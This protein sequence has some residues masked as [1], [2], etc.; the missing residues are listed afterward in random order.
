MKKSQSS[1]YFSRLEKFLGINEEGNITISPILIKNGSYQTYD[2]IFTY[3][4]LDFGEF[5]DTGYRIL[6][7]IDNDELILIGIGYYN[8]SGTTSDNFDIY[9]VSMVN[10][11]FEYIHLDNSEYGSEPIYQSVAFMEHTQSK[12]YTHRLTLTADKSYTLIYESTNNLNVSSI[13]DLRTITNV[14]A[15]S[16]N[17]ILPVCLTDLSGTAALQ[18]TTTLC[19]VGTA[20]VTAVSDKVTTL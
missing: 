14:K 15:T 16:D 19:K 1:E 5:K 17:V 18:I 8:I 13:A 11:D 20:N 3:S 7:L 12:L 2:G 9:G 10:N 4:V 6:G